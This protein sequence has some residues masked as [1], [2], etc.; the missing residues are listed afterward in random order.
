MRDLRRF[1]LRGE[2]RFQSFDRVVAIISLFF[3][4]ARFLLHGKG[5][6]EPIVKRNVFASE[7]GTVVEVLVQHGQ[8]VKEGQELV[9]LEIATRTWCPLLK[10]ML[11]DHRSMS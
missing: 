2:E 8:E 5:T 3:V 4:P 9:K 7:Q 11:V 6:L 10:M 1:R